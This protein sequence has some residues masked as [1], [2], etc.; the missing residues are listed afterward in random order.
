[1]KSLLKLCYISCL[2][3][4]LGCSKDIG[5]YEYKDVNAIKIGGLKEG[6]HTTARIYPIPFGEELKLSPTYEGTLSGD[7]LSDLDFEWTVDGQ[8]VSNDKELVYLA[9]KLYGRLKAELKVK[10]NSTSITTS[11]HFFIDVINRF[12]SGYYILSEKANEDA[13]LYCISNIVS[14]LRVENVDIPILQGMGKKPIMLNG[15]HKYGSSA[16]DFWNYLTLVVQDATY[17]VSLIDSRE[18]MPLRLYN[19]SAYL[20][21]GDFKLSPTAAWGDLSSN[22]NIFIVNN[23]K[24][25]LLLKGIISDPMY[26]QDPLDYDAGP[27]GLFQPSLMLTSFDYADKFFATYDFR[28]K[29]VRL[30]SNQVGLAYQFNVNHDY[31]IDASKLEGHTFLYGSNDLVGN[32]LI[33]TFMTRKGDKLHCFNVDLTLASRVASGFRE[34]GSVDIPAGADISQISFNDQTKAFLLGIGKT[35][36]RVQNLAVNNKLVLEEYLKLPNDAPGEISCFNF[37]AKRY[38]STDDNVILIATTDQNAP[39]DKKSSIYIYNQADFS[40][41]Y[42]NK[43]AVEKVKGLYV[44]I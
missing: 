18:F 4:L 39:T 20:G 12:K 34:I 33:Y 26:P 29:T 30:V 38:G 42:A 5:N 13:T 8:V 1:M 10:D 3:L 9:N 15:K 28:N 21:G 16:S 25:H 43:Y 36:Y 35:V 19:S 22:E 24:Y 6:N 32:S 11:Y 31:A 7:N 17:P 27:N 23:G 40:L 44:G 41:F 14:P 37:G 2:M